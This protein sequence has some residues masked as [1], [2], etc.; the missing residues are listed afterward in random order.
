MSHLDVNGRLRDWEEGKE[1]TV[2]EDSGKAATNHDLHAKKVI[3]L[4]GRQERNSLKRR[5]LSM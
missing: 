4:R 5:G 1:S 3:D 2:E